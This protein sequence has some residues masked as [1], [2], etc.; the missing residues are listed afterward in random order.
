ML[1]PALI[2]IALCAATLAMPADWPQFRGPNAAGVSDAVGLPMEFG[3][4]TSVLW[5]TPLPPGHSSPAIAGDRIFVTAF[6]KADLYTIAMDRG[7][8]RVLWR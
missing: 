5:K 7:S 1:R 6:D 4:N 8:G 2:P 3:P